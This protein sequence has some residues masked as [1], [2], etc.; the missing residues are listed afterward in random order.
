M[1]TT[2]WHPGRL[3]ELSGMYW[4]TCTLHAGVKLGIFSHLADRR[5]TAE[6]L[7]D[8]LGADSRAMA[9]LLNALSAMGLLEKADGGFANT[10]AARAYLVQTSPGYVGHMILHHHDLVA[11][12]A[13]LDDAVLT[14]RPVRASVGR[15][16]DEARRKNFLMGMFNNAMLLAPRIVEAVD[17]SGRRSLLDLG[18]GPGTYAIHF[19]LENPQLTATVYDL[20][21]TRPFAQETIER[22]GVADRVAF[23]PGDYHAD[24]LPGAYDA[25]W[26]SHILHAEGPQECLSILQK[27]VGAL[28]PGGL[29]LVHDF[30]LEDSLAAP[31]F[32]ALFSLNMLLG[33]SAGRSY[34][35]TAVKEMLSRCGVTDIVQLEFRG[36]T[37][38]GIISGI[39]W[40]G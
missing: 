4:Q 3:L 27:A 14:G 7:A 15:S 30:L 1:N 31:L 33:T 32:P 17:L 22:F 26:I 23:A 40:P 20:P 10:A 38:S 39:A 9:C 36:P 12:W 28:S 16:D 8:C 13:R 5:L 21:T 2:D 29:I 6:S 11:S 34:S 25:V 37:Q 35:G 24:P 19:C 18:G